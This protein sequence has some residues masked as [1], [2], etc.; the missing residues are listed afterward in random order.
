MQ[1]RKNLWAASWSTV[2]I[3]SLCLLSTSTFLIAMVCLHNS[4]SDSRKNGLEFPNAE[5]QHCHTHEKQRYEVHP[6]VLEPGASQNY[7]A[8][9]LQEMSQG[10]E[11]SQPLKG[12]RHRLTRENES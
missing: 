12:K 6:Q 2:P 10:N 5:K 3:R 1:I 7:A 4:T 8:L 11:V 9:N